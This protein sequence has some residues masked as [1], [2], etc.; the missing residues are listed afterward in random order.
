MAEQHESNAA[1]Q[2]QSIDRADWNA[3]L[4]RAKNKDGTDGPVLPV[5][6]NLLAILTHDER[7]E[8]VIAYDEFSGSIVKRKL[9]PT[10]PQALGEWLD[11]DDHRIELWFAQTYGLRRIGNGDLQKAVFLAADGNRFHEVRD[12]LDTIV[13]DGAPRVGDLLM[14][15]FGAAKSEYAAAVGTK[16]LVSAVARIYEPGC[17]ADHVLILEGPQGAGKSTALSVL[18]HPWFT[19]ASF[20]LRNT[21]EAGQVIRGMWG[22]ELSELDGFNRAESSAA[23]AFFSRRTDRYRN[24]YGRKPVTLP[25]QQVFAGTV[26]HGTYLRDETGNRRYWPVSVGTEGDIDLKGL[27]EI[28]DQLLAEAVHLYKAGTVWYVRASERDMFH[29]QQE[30]RYEGDAYEGR[31]SIWLDDPERKD[32][33]SFTMNQILRSALELDVSKWTRAEQQRVGRIMQHRLGWT[34]RKLGTR[35]SRTWVYQ[36]PGTDGAASEV[37]S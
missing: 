1:R 10:M 12:F 9:P 21:Q 28:R 14:A 23:K 29:E 25:R 31:I 37:E 33:N 18:F 20:D 6:E 36:R 34:R 32:I 19:D 16:W 30:E 4:L 3:R 26:N 22:V 13:W 27:A 8:G 17:K 5:L 11:E 15:Y 24:P 2:F 7:W 35:A